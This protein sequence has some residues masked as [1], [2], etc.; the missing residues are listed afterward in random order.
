[1]R[2]LKVRIGLNSDNKVIFT[3]PVNK[4]TGKVVETITARMRIITDDEEHA[5]IENLMQEGSVYIRN[6]GRHREIR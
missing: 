1:M 6:H 3:D 2:D 4:V 5:S